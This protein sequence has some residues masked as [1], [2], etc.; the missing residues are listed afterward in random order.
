MARRTTV[1]THPGVFDI[2]SYESPFSEVFQELLDK[3]AFDFQF[4][5]SGFTLMRVESVIRGSS[6]L[7]PSRIKNSKACSVKRRPSKNA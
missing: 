6:V 1:L 2:R 7:F 3:S 5:D 4:I